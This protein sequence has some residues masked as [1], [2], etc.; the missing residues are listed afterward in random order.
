[1][2]GHFGD[3]ILWQMDLSSDGSLLLSGTCVLTGFSKGNG[4]GISTAEYR[5]EKIS[6][7][8]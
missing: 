2:A 4:S 3:S 8:K 6:T 1:M 7:G 5:E